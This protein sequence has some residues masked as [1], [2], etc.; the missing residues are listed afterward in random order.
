MNFSKLP[1][2]LFLRFCPILIFCSISIFADEIPDVYPDAD[3]RL[4]YL[5]D[6]LGNR[7]PDFSNAGYLGG[8]VAIPDV[9]VKKTLSPQAGDNRSRIQAAIDQVA[10]MPLDENGFRGAILLKAGE[11]EIGNSLKIS[12]SGIV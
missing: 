4:S 11:Y 9:P 12:S 2:S 10:A 3:G 7:V 6:D 5:E 8:G 1:F